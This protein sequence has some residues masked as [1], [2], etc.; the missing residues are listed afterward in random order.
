M[1]NVEHVFVLML[2]NRAF[3]HLLGFSG[4]SGTDAE[5]GQATA[6]RGLTGGETNSYQGSSYSVARPADWA[7]AVDPG[8]EF[9]QVVEQL[10][11]QGVTY[12]PGGAYPAIDNS[13]F[14]ASYSEVVSGAKLQRSPG[15]ILKCFSPDQLPV[16]NALVREFA[17][18]DGWHASMPGP[19]WPN[20]LFVHAGTSGGL[21]H[22][23]TNAEIVLWETLDGYQLANG[24]IFD[25]LKAKGLSRRLYAGDDFP[26]VSCLK[27]IELGDI[28]DYKNF[29][30]DLNDPQYPYSYVFIEP[31]YCV[32]QDYRCSTSEHPLDDI[33]RG[34]ALI[35]HCYESI[36]NSPVWES[37]VLV[38]TWD[39]HGG[40]YDHAAPPNTVA[41]GDI[42][43]EDG[44]NK[45]GFTF[46]QLGV[47]VPAV[48][49][50]PWV[51]RNAVDHR[52]YDHASVPATLEAL[53]GLA[54]LTARDSGARTVLPLLSLET[55]RSDT[56]ERL[57]QPANSGIGGCPPA[58]PGL[59]AASA[60]VSVSAPEVVTRP[61][62]TI[63][64]GNLPV[65]V[66]AAMRQ[67]FEVSPRAARPQILARVA[68][69]RTRGD[70]ALYL[71]EVKKKVELARA[72]K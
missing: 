7:M 50:S 25:R 43:A 3:D 61:R 40:F 56:P 41:P 48:V 62:D 51:A 52:V 20:R 29:E 5:T 42:P 4:L 13:G 28:R 45:Y 34:E 66:H 57:P 22:S 24:T 11:G 12:A 9:P 32:Q 6:V 72:G 1:A 38:L 21:D 69:L 55:A 63:N 15:E 19:T 71:A 37:S 30:Q 18:C 31:S 49:I 54:P 47:R 17:I 59:A 36:R 16:L 35:K 39:E 14:V 53:F 26:M 8:H 44:R 2:E 27:G 23:P 46:E 65:V 58:I 33:T 10:C 64:D 70:A 67:D 60:K 68:G